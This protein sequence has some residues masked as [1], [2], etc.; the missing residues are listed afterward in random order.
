[1]LAY[2]LLYQILSIFSLKFS[3]FFLNFNFIRLKWIKLYQQEKQKIAEFSEQF[4]NLS[5]KITSKL[6]VQFLIFSRKT[7]FKY[8]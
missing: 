7:K 4:L 2:W 1:M 3:Y 8:L 5:D 6:N